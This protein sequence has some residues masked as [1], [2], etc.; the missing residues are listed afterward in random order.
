MLITT[1]LTCN[2]CGWFIQNPRDGNQ[3]PRGIIDAIC[4]S[5]GKSYEETKSEIKKVDEPYEI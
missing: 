4:C 5:C 3:R 2:N 1:I